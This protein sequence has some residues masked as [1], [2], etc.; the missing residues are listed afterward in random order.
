VLLAKAT[1]DEVRRAVK[2]EKG[3]GGKKKGIPKVKVAKP[4]GQKNNGAAKPAQEA[5]SPAGPPAPG[6]QSKKIPPDKAASLAP[7]PVRASS[8]PRERRASSLLF[9]R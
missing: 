4:D 1:R 8:F 5:K 6:A 7:L 2:S 9:P 3:D